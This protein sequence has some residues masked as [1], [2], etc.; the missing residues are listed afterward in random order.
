MAFKFKN[1]RLFG[2]ILFI[3]LAFNTQAQKT[4]LFYPFYGDDIKYMGYSINYLN[5]HDVNCASGKPLDYEYHGYS[6][7]VVMNDNN[8]W[9]G[10]GILWSLHWD[11][12][13]AFPE[14]S[15]YEI[16]GAESSF[17]HQLHLSFKLPL[18]ND[19]AL[20]FHTG[21]GLVF[22]IAN[23]FYGD[24][25]EEDDFRPFKE[26]WFKRFNFSYDYAV[27]LEFRTWRF[28][29]SWIKGLRDNGSELDPLRRNR[30]MFG[31]VKFDFE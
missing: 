12:S 5:S 26:K 29:V 27:Y 19:F 9:H 10:L 25:G 23:V 15:L 18:S 13:L 30:I 17:Y 4:Y 14:N 20:G 7:G 28:E 8:I 24:V 21:P 22:G 1:K 3:A 31:F 11:L 6:F 2:T 16:L